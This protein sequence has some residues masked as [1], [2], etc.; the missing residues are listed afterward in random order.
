MLIVPV[1][2]P[3]SVNS[4]PVAC[5]HVCGKNVCVC[6]YMLGVLGF[7]SVLLQDVSAS[8]SPSIHMLPVGK[9]HDQL[10]LFFFSAY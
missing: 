8:H 4:A 3:A 10:L 5:V 9:K 1:R 7:S 6:V 2:A